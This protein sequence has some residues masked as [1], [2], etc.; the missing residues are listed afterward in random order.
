MRNPGRRNKA[1]TGGAKPATG[2]VAATCRAL[3][4][5]VLALHPQAVEAHWPRLKTVS[6]GIG[7]RKMSQH[8]AYLAVFKGHVNIG[9]YHGVSLRAPGIELEGAGKRLRHVKVGS[10]SAANALAMRRLIH[11]A[12]RERT[13]NGPAA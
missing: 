5:V 1:S 9:F 12:I 7:P 6:F 13:A 8:Y 4:Q 11:A 2:D 10:V 3:R